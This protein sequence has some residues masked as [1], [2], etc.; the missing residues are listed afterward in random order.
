MNVAIALSSVFVFNNSFPNVSLQLV[1]SMF[2]FVWQYILSV[3]V[4][5]YFYARILIVIRH[6]AKAQ[7]T[8]GSTADENNVRI[9]KASSR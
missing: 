9:Q 6:S 1:Y 3:A 8:N 4:L 7:G 5:V 2:N